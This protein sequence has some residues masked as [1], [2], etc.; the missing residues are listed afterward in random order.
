[1]LE[2]LLGAVSP[3]RPPGVSRAGRPRLPGMALVGPEVVARRPGARDQRRRRDPAADRPRQGV[4][5]RGVQVDPDGA[6][7][8]APQVN[9]QLS[10]SGNVVVLGQLIMRPISAAI[11]HTL[12]VDVDESRFVGGGMT[13]TPPTSGSG[14]LSTG[15]ST[16]KARRS[17]L[18]PR[19]RFARR[20][21]PDRPARRRPGWLG[22]RRRDRHHPDRPTDRRRLLRPRLRHGAWRRSATAL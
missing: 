9:A 22:A 1:M 21:Q 15:S 12:L 20:R 8:F 17:V 5:V 2:A 10:S 19:H 18:G 6:L 4:A 13:V 14:S 16:S 11:R 3:W 7:V